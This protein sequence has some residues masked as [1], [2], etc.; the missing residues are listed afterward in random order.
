MFKD[1]AGGAWSN[2]VSLP[3]AEGW[4][5]MVFQVIFNLNQPMIVESGRCISGV[6]AGGELQCLSP[7]LIPLMRTRGNSVWL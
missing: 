4:N 5:E 6:E 2:G 1:R 3:V 7:L